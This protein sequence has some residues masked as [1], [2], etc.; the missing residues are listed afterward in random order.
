MKEV[1]VKLPL[2][3][4]RGYKISVGTGVIKRLGSIYDLERYS[5]IFIVTDDT[6][7]PM[8]LDAL[9]SSL[10]A[11]PASLTLP[12]GEKHKDIDTVGRIW[13]AMHEAGCDRKSLVI[14]LGGG[15][16]GDIGG[17]AA[18]TY[19][20]G[21]DF[22]NIP[23]TLL[24]QVDAS[25]GGK[26]GFNFDGIKN[27]VGTISQP[28]GIVIDTDTLASLPERELTAGFAEIIKHGAI[29]DAAYFDKVVARRPTEYSP[30]ALADIIAESCRIKAAV[31][32]D[33]ETEAGKRK[34][35]NF[36]HTVGH[37]V[38]ALSHQTDKPLLHGEA[39]SIGMMAEAD[40][41]A[42]L[43]RLPAED[44]ERLRQ[45][46]TDAG[47]PVSVRGLDP[48]DIREKMRSDKKNTGGRLN[49]TLLDGIGRASYDQEVAEPTVKEALRT[50]LE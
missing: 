11:K 46:L 15:V 24:A 2:S 26:T 42:R 33:D 31:V 49:F 45:A 5:R 27:L 21:V 28:V 4:S 6:V 12:A 37:A 44:L 16:I 38:E 20:R 35:L 48:D 41:S 10:P 3:G 8:F 50:V 32:H 9:S 36:G 17:F 23:T 43:G 19:M 30:E 14:N 13:T 7:K 25:V 47:L 40:I 18:S 29:S 1:S 39:I 22:L 34:L